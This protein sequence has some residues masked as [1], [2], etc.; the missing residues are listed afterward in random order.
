MKKRIIN[1]NY[2]NNNTPTPLS[3]GERLKV[4]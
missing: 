1:K 2:S 4:R 3:F